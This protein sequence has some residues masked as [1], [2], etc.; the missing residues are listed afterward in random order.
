MTDTPKH[1]RVLVRGYFTA[2]QANFHKEASGVLKSDISS[3][4]L[5][6]VM[7]QL[8]AGATSIEPDF[9]MTNV[10][11]MTPEE[12]DLYEQGDSDNGE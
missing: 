11:P 9:P 12:I 8:I 10:R 4:A 5:L 1:V 7:P 2:D 3:A 6:R